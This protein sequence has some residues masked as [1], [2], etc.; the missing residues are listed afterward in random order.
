MEQGSHAATLSLLFDY[1][2]SLQHA[3]C[4][5]WPVT[6]GKRLP[7]RRAYL[8]RSQNVN[9]PLFWVCASSALP[10]CLANAWKSR[11]EPVSVAT[12]RKTSPLA[13]S[14]SAFLALRIGSGQ[15][16]PRA[17]RSFWTSMVPVSIVVSLIDCLLVGG[18]DARIVLQLQDYDAP[19]QNLVCVLRC[20]NGNG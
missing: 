13:S 4:P 2:T 11:T 8:R 12:M 1:F 3:C 19:H 20:N 18:A 16:K 6:A 5:A 10:V 14:A 9:S 7:G 17:S 15:F